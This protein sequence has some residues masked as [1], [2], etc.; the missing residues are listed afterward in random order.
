MSALPET[1]PCREEEFGDIYH[2]VYSKITDNT[3][4]SVAHSFYHC[5]SKVTVNTGVLVSHFI[6]K[7]M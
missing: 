6:C 4:G 5:T 1:L 3:G 2:F 7:K